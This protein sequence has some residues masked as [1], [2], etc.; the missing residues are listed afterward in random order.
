M[1]DDTG[2]AA[3]EASRPTREKRAH[4][5]SAPAGNSAGPDESASG[6]EGAAIDLDTVRDRAS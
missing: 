6:D 1:T 4:E 3:G 5:P 2:G